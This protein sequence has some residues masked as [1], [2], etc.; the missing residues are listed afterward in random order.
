V[1]H[2]VIPEGSRPFVVLPRL[3]VTVFYWLFCLFVYVV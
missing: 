3:V 1:T 2:T